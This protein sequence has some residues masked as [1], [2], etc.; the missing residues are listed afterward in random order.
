M[1]RGPLGYFPP[2]PIRTLAANMVKAAV[3]R[4]EYMEDLEQKPYWLDT[5]L[6]TLAASAGKADKNN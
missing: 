6:A 5:R 4:K 2:E 1:A 3:K